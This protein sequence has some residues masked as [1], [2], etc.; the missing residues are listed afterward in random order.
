MRKTSRRRIAQTVVRL[1]RDR[2]QDRTR[3]LRELAAYLIVHKQENRLDLLLL[4]IAHELEINAGHL[5]AE[6]TSAYALD[7]S[8]RTELEAYLKKAT[9]AK[10][11]ELDETVDGSLLAGAIVRTADRELDTSARSKLTKL[12]SL[13]LNTPE[14][15]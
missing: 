4:D 11:V 7:A 8:A 5:Y 6:V 14:K 15:A 9:G 12:A 2:P 10:Q 3:I 1:L 13:H